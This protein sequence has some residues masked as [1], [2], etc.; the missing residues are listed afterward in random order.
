MSQRT[1]ITAADV[2]EA[3]TRIEEGPAELALAL[4]ELTQT[5]VDSEP[6]ERLLRR[7]AELAVAVVPSRTHAGVTLLEGGQAVTAAC[8][9]P[10]VLVLDQRQYETGDGPCLDAVRSGTINRTSTADSSLRWPQLTQW[11]REEGV[12][13]LLAAPLV[14]GGLPVGA[15]NLYGTRPDAFAAVDDELV[16]L[17]TAQASVALTN[18]RLYRRATA[19]NAQ[20]AEAMASRAVIEQAK[21]VLVGTRGLTPDEAFLELRDLSQHRNQKLREVALEVVAEAARRPGAG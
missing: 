6:L 11:A 18:A 7:V 9:D 8:T 20:L 12:H 17:F 15:L 1:D 5:L 16:L 10:L 4:A 2:T 19:L 13:S 3:L 21:G 14:A